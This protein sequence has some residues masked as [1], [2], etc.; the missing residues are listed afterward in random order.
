MQE[1]ILVL[2]PTKLR[3]TGRHA[4]LS[5]YLVARNQIYPDS[6]ANA[7]AGFT[8]PSYNALP[9]ITPSI[10]V[11]FAASLS[12]ARCASDPTPPEATTGVVRRSDKA[13]VCSRFSP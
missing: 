4:N 1:H 2:G 11:A 7:S 6:S 12:A 9:T 10:R 8:R 5:G 13:T 3:M